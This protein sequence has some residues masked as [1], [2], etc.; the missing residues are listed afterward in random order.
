MGWWRRCSPGTWEWPWTRPPAWRL[1]CSRARGTHRS[2]S[3]WDFGLYY[4]GRDTIDPDDVRALGYSGTVVAP[5]QWAYPMN[6]G[7]WLTVG[8][9]KVDL[10][11]R[12]LDDVERW[13][14]EAE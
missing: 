5:G 7:A 8:D 12:D 4:R 10:L 14:T 3:D 1:G 6:G 2:D 13:S 11:Y 9:R